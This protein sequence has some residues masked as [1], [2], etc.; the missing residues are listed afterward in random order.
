MLYLG[1]HCTSV[2]CVF[3]RK[4]D[5]E[6]STERKEKNHVGDNNVNE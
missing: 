5:D 2:I 1:L 4:T 3:V 6:C